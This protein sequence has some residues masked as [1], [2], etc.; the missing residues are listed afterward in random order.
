VHVGI[1]AL[2]LRQPVS[3]LIGPRRPGGL[4]VLVHVVSQRARV[5]RLRRADR[6]LAIY[7]AG[8]F[9]FLPLRIESAPCSSVFRSPIARPTDTPDLRFDQH[10]A[11]LTA[12]LGAKM[13][14]LSPFLYDS[15][16]R[17]NMPV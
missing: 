14:S 3:I 15:F 17:Y 16:I 5:L 4:P 13:D 2:G 6:P 8:R 10:L 9:A 1:V 11:I 12:R 7:A